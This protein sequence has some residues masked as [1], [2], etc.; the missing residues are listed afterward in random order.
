MSRRMLYRAIWIPSVLVLAGLMVMF[1]TKSAAVQPPGPMVLYTT[2]DGVISVK[3]PDNWKPHSLTLHDVT[4]SVVFK[5]ASHEG[6]SIE[7]NLAGSLRADIDRSASTVLGNLPGGQ[8]LSAK[9]THSPYAAERAL[10]YFASLSR[11]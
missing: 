6:L 8:E 11:G 3:H 4:T 10:R 5:S 7:A 9:L 2:G 1:A